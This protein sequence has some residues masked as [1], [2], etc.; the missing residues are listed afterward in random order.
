M[1][2]LKGAAGTRQRL[3][4]KPLDKRRAKQNGAGGESFLQQEIAGLSD[5]FF[6]VLLK[7]PL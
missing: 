1:E 7:D 6:P 3:R 5:I 2:E 4:T